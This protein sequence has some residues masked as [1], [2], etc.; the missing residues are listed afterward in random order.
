MALS[1]SKNSNL[2]D[3]QALKKLGSGSFNR[4]NQKHRLA[5]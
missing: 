5:S 4:W 3:F 1:R 2:K